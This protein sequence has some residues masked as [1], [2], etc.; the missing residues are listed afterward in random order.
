M[1]S[2]KF[3]EPT[4]PVRVP[5]SMAER[6]DK[7]L[8]NPTSALRHYD[9]RVAAGTPLPVAEDDPRHVQINDLLKVRSSSSFIVTVRGDS[10]DGASIHD[11]DHLVVDPDVE[12]KSG[13]IVIA[14]V[15]GEVTVKRLW[16]GRGE[17]ELR[18]ENPRHSPIKIGPGTDVTIQGVVKT[19]I[20][21]I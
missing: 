21:P 10:M 6:F 9:C 13:D 20:R 14:S 3:G 15:D 4:V 17:S 19:V 1:G 12:P 18:P 8:E 7:W 11:N 5:R 2:G 16:K